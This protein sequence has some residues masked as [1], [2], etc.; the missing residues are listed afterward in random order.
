MSHTEHHIGKLKK[1]L[2]LPGLTVEQ[3]MLQLLADHGHTEMPSYYKD[4]REWF[5]NEISERK[6]FYYKGDVYSLDDEDMEDQ[7]IIKASRNDDGSISYHLMF[8]NG[9]ASF[10]ECLEEALDKLPV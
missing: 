1:V 5:S 2:P 3:Q 4:V 10:G 9:G 6:Y 8:Y 7:D